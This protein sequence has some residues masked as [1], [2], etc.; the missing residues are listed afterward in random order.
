M[1]K[2]EWSKKKKKANSWLQKLSELCHF[3]S[4]QMPDRDTELVPITL[5]E[6][7]IQISH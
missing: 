3:W 5:P 2:D 4:E 1:N 6:Y 7:I